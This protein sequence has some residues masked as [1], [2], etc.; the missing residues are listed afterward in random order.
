MS[1]RSQTFPFLLLSLALLGCATPATTAAPVAAKTS[2]A[3]EVSGFDS[4]RLARLDTA[5]EGYVARGE[6]PGAVLMVLKDG[7]VAHQGVYGWQDIESRTPM[8]ADSL[9]RIASQTKALVSVGIMMLQEEGRLLIGDR[10]DRYLPEWA[11]TTVAVPKDEGGYEV[12][13]AKRPIT[14]RDL[15]THTAGIGYGGGPA[16]DAWAAAG[17]QGWYFADRKEPIRETVRRMAA[18]PQEAHPGETY[19]YGYATDILGAVIEVVSGQ[20]LDIFLQERLFGPLGMS[21]THFYLPPE[22]SARLATVYGYPPEQNRLARA[23]DTSNM[24]GQGDYVRG[25]RTSFSGGA[26]LVSSAHDYARFLSMLLNGGELDGRRYLSRNTV[27]LMTSNHL[28][29]VAFP[30]QAGTGFGLGFS[31][32]LDTGAR[33]VPG[34][35]GEYGWGGAYHSNYWVDPAE[36]LVVVY[37]TQVIPAANLDDHGKL[38]ALVYQALE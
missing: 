7:A 9:F 19:V 36:R 4:Q 33:G 37:F 1:Y 26:G 13:P 14:L 2:V 18:L 10:L 30:W 11:A 12:V 32:A 15:L 23:P 28:G 29:Q 16:G 3:A 20:S 25:P 5:F 8:A 17:I 22:K 31:V 21:D 34:S 6:L 38:R 27:D 24:T 35:V